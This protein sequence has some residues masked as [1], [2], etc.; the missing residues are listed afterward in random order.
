MRAKIRFRLMSGYGVIGLFAACN[1]PMPDGY[2]S[3]Q[4]SSQMA[5]FSIVPVF[6]PRADLQVGDIYLSCDDATADGSKIIK[7]DHSVV[8]LASLPGMLSTSRGKTTTNGL[9]TAQY[10]TRVQ[11]PDI[12]IASSEITVAA[13]DTKAA[14]APD[15]VSSNAKDRVK[16]NLTK[17]FA[18]AV[19]K[20]PE[21]KEAKVARATRDAKDKKDKVAATPV[22]NATPKGASAV[23]VSDIFASSRPKRLMPVSLPEF[24]SVSATK[25]QAQALIPF[26]SILAK[27]NLSYS[28]AR[29]IEVSVPEA[30]SYGVPAGVMYKLYFEAVKAKEMDEALH[31][32]SYYSAYSDPRGGFCKYGTPG[33]VL[34]YE[35]Y[36]TR[37][38]NVSVTFEKTI[39]GDAAAGLYYASGTSEATVLGA[40][41]K[42]LSPAPASGTSG[43]SAPLVPETANGASAPT[44]Q[45]ATAYVEQLNALYKQLDGGAQNQQYPGVQVSIIS[46]NGSGVVMNRQFETPVVIGYRGIRVGAPDGWTDPYNPPPKK[47]GAANATASSPPTSAAAR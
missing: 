1:S 29:N 5:Q 2:V 14:S 17:G 34:I 43:A 4:W 26:P 23:E 11:M 3:D 37:A 20:A 39:E 45:Q 9:L 10:L 19:E 21:A 15:A 8:W 7:H 47:Q 6:P 44:I 13:S 27:A 40:L 33:M 41:S 28:K 24:F 36:A 12:P 38:I 32:Y 31:I 16:K 25:E 42:Y 18:A 35:I 30:E 22:A 46:G